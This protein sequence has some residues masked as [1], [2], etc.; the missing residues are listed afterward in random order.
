MGEGG[1]DPDRRAVL[2][3]GLGLGAGLTLG[4]CGDG[5]LDRLAEAGRG[6]VLEVAS[7]DA[8][9]IEPGGPLRL[10]GIMAPFAGAPGA[11]TARAALDALTLGEEVE[12]LSGGA[13]ADPTGRKVAHARRLKGRL[14]LEGA[15]LDAGLAAVRTFAD[16]RALAAEM[17]E[18]EARAR[19][20]GKGLWGQGALKVL[21][22]Q[23]VATSQRGFAI[24]EGRVARV[25]RYGQ[26]YDL[27]LIEG[28]RRVSG[29]IPPEALA[30]FAAA[31]KAAA[32]MPGK[33]VRVRGALRPGGRMRLDHPEA[34]EVLGR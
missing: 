23:E 4:G 15:M 19:V 12:L 22:P 28:G 3:G 1:H 8:L 9:V 20:A 29:E 11:E 33:L 16:N 10:A 34:L 30:D 31:G 27:D 2:L 26:G 7:G 21:L 14:W 32:E 25:R 6:R 13:L 17:L 18:R 5:G 24:V